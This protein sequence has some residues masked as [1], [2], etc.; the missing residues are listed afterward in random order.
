MAMPIVDL[1]GQ[2]F[3]C[4][5]VLAMWSERQGRHVLWQCR[6]DC[7]ARQLIV[8]Y[9]LRNG[10]SKSCGCARGEDR[11][12]RQAQAWPCHC[13]DHW[14]TKLT[15]GF[16]TMVSSQDAKL[17]QDEVWTA[18]IFQ[19]KW[20]IYAKRGKRSVRLH[21][22]ILPDAIQVD[23]KNRNG[24]DNRRENLRSA[25]ATLNG[26]NRAK[27]ATASSFFKGVSYH[28]KQALSKPWIARCGG[29]D[30]NYLGSFTTEIEAAHAYDN[31]ARELYGP[32]ARTN[33]ASEE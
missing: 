22:E 17:I 6:C 31:A 28:L 4:W 20:L 2:R 24:L 33:F 8:G 12:S 32:F 26:G 25:N 9:S 23:H 3:G 10:R 27:L 19:S 29:R 30:R 1:T 16:I 7:G 13:G 14:W 21:R 5:T 15:N 18:S 11:K